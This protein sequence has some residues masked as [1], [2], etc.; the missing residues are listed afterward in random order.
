W[1]FPLTF[2][3]NAFVPLQ[4]MP[5]VLQTIAIWNPVSSVVS[6]ARELFGNPNPYVGNSLPE[7]HPITFSVVWIAVLLAVFVPIAVRRYRRTTTR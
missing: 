2:L 1:L 3:S 4:G 7:Q 5:P 6:A